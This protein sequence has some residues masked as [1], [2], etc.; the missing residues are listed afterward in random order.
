MSISI[1]PS[2]L[3]E[4]ITL[5]RERLRRECLPRAQDDYERNAINRIDSKLEIMATQLRQSIFTERSQRYSEITRMVEEIDPVV[6]P[7]E[8]GRLLIEIEDIYRRV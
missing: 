7:V 5:I 8:I 2:K 1:E 3:L 6:I 4:T